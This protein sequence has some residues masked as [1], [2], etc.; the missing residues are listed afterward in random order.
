MASFKN[1]L[2]DVLGKE[3]PIDLARAIFRLDLFN[4]MKYCPILDDGLQDKYD[5]LLNERSAQRES[6][7]KAL[8]LAILADSQATVY[9]DTAENLVANETNNW[10]QYSQNV[11]LHG[12]WILEHVWSTFLP[13]LASTIKNFFIR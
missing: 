11:F 4:V 1:V 5:E 12:T 6:T 7:M 10:L 2:T 13:G 8:T 9:D 3:I